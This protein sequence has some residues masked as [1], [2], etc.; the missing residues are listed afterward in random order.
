[1]KIRLSA[2]ACN[3]YLGSEN[4]FGGWLNAGETE[5]ATMPNVSQLP[6]WFAGKAR[7]DYCRFAASFCLWNLAEDEVFPRV[8]TFLNG[9]TNPAR[10]LA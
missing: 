4:Y 7:L 5:V 8:E 10:P 3:P 1:M 2:I 6:K 9:Q